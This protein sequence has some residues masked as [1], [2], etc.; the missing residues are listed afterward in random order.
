MRL[1]LGSALAECN[2]RL[3]SSLLDKGGPEGEVADEEL[4][5]PLEERLLGTVR[6]QAVVTLTSVRFVLNRIRLLDRFAPLHALILLPG[7][8]VPSRLQLQQGDER[9]QAVQTR[10][11]CHARLTAGTD[12]RPVWVTARR[13]I[14]QGK[15]SA[16][17]SHV[18]GGRARG[19]SEHPENPSGDLA[20][21][22]LF[23]VGE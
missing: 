12:E 15:Q 14:H 9:F 13:G 3:E 7:L 18:A 22:L 16:G 19:R 11:N 10:Y 21:V 1:Q 2:E 4:R 23:R 5:D 8:L 17:G 20:D 6:D